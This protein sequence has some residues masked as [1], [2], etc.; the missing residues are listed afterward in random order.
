VDGFAVHAVIRDGSDIV[1]EHG[2]ANN[3]RVDGAMAV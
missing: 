2:A 1:Y 3:H